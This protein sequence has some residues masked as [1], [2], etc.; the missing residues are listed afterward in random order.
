VAKSGYQ[1]DNVLNGTLRDASFVEP[2]AIWV[3]LFIG[4]TGT[5]AEVTGAGYSRVQHGPGDTFWTDPAASGESANIGDLTYGEP[6]TDWGVMFDFG[7]F[8]SQ[9]GGNELYRDNLL[10]PRTVLAGQGA[11]RFEDGDLI[12]KEV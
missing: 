6:T 12:V 9:T 3:A 5:G 7:Q 4:P 1:S 11:P 8:D 10:A 2:A